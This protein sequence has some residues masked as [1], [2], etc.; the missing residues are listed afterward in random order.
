M[1]EAATCGR[2]LQDTAG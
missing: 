1:I 2:E